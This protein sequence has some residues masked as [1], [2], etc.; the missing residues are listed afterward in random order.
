[1]L[2]A[3]YDGQSLRLGGD[4]AS[5][6]REPGPERSSS[7]NGKVFLLKIAYV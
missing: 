1:M 4:I 3:V 5:A 2:D 7:A 6:K